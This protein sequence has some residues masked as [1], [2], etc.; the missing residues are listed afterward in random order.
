MY[1]LQ[2]KF[3]TKPSQ[4]DTLA[5]ILLEASAL[6]TNAQGC[7]LYVISLAENDANAVYVTEIWE[8]KSD[9]DNSLHI[10]GV[11]ELIAQAIPLLAEPPSKG[12]ELKVLGGIGV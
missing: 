12:Q 4:S 9:H 10:A 2:G 8:S 7:K 1:L 6:M 3:T 11:K 5:N